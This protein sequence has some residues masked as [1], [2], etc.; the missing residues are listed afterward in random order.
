MWEFVRAV[1]VS[2]FLHYRQMS[3]ENEMQNVIT[4]DE[5]FVS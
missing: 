4:G 5:V 2:V 3:S 1:L